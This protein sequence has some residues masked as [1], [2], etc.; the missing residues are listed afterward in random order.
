VFPVFQ[1]QNLR[2][3]RVELEWLKMAHSMLTR[4]KKATK[5]LPKAAKRPETFH[6]WMNLPADIRVHILG[7]WLMLR[8]ILNLRATSKQ[9]KMEQDDAYATGTF[10]S[11]GFDEYT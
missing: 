6:R 11:F 3:W 5:G 1:P 7:N 4:G 8:S 10:K 2:T 9:M